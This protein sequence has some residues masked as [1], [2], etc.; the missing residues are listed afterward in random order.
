[1]AAVTTRSH[2]SRGRHEITHHVPMRHGHRT[3]RFD[4]RLE[5]RHHGAIRSE[6][7]AEPHRDQPC[8]SALTREFTIERLIGRN[9]HP[10]VAAGAAASQYISA[11]RLVAPRTDTGSRCEGLLACT[12]TAD[13]AL[14]RSAQPLPDIIAAAELGPGRRV[15][16]GEV[17]TIA[18]FG[19]TQ[20]FT[21]YG[22]GIP[23]EAKLAVVGKPG[24]LQ[25]RLV[26]AATLN[27]KP[28]LGACTGDSGAPAFD[29]DGMLAR[30]N[31]QLV[32]STQ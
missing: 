17:L 10:A 28:G 5:F 9:Q 7:I 3:A 18:G 32:D 2:A 13:L 27:K 4:L 14:V 22:R 25:I 12:A 8:S 15:D 16:V 30:W 21:P 31:S 24:S 20:A 1:M 19:V 11:K 23:R 29:S 6:H 26:D